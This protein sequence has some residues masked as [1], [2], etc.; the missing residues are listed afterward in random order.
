MLPRPRRGLTGRSLGISCP[1]TSDLTPS[2]ILSDVKEEA[3][4][5]AKGDGDVLCASGQGVGE[6]IATFPGILPPLARPAALRLG[7]VR[8]PGCGVPAATP[9]RLPTTPRQRD[10]VFR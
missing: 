7:T 4:P 8:M 10:G 5:P 1:D 6:I 2:S 3:S 9:L